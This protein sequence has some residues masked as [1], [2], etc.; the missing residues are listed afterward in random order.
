VLGSEDPSLLSAGSIYGEEAGGVG[1]AR[2]GTWAVGGAVE[3][4]REPVG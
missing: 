1:V 3:L 2:G 4:E